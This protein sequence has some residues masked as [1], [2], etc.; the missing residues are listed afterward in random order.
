M[1]VITTSEAASVL[2]WR[3]PVQ[4]HLETPCEKSRSLT[5]W[6]TILTK[7][8]YV[9]NQVTILDVASKPGDLKKQR[10]P[11]ILKIPWDASFL[12]DFNVLNG[13]ADHSV[14]IPPELVVRRAEV[15]QTPNVL[16]CLPYCM[17]HSRMQ[18]EKD[19]HTIS[20]QTDAFCVQ[21]VHD[22]VVDKPRCQIV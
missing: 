22:V 13:I 6:S 2:C 11:R 5:I 16:P 9:H 21:N 1:R 4:T 15:L 10:R 7:I 20:M 3:A 14:A 18:S 19:V 8:G 12:A 17:R